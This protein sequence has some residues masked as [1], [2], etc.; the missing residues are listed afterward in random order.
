MQLRQIEDSKTR[1]LMR[2]QKAA[3]KSAA[4]EDSEF[5]GVVRGIIKKEI[6]VNKCW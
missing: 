6:V 3:L 4:N 2:A 1:D 5:L